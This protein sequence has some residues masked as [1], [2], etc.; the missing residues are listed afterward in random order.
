MYFVMFP[1]YLHNQQFAGNLNKVFFISYLFIYLFFAGKQFLQL[2][3]LNTF[4]KGNIQKKIYYFFIAAKIMRSF[5]FFFFCSQLQS[6]SLNHS[7]LVAASVARIKGTQKQSHGQLE[8]EKSCLQASS[9][10]SLNW[11]FLDFLDA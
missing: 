1:L 5:N 11:E 2:R 9:H 3:L 8:F 10:V 6:V 4:H 7:F